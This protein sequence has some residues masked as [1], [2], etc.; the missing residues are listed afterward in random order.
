MNLS[1]GDIVTLDIGKVAHGG[2]FISRHNNQVV[3]VRH[4]ITGEIA[5]VKIT[6]INSKIAFGDA[7]EILKSS[8]YRVKPPC[9]YS[10]PGGCGG[11]DFQHISSMFQESLKKTIIEDQFKRITK[12]NVNV[13]I[14]S[15]K[16]FTG[17]HWRSRINLAISDNGKA[18]LYLYK[19]NDII[20]IDKCLI[21]VEEINKS[22]VFDKYWSDKKKLN[23]AV[24]SEKKLNIN[25][26]GNNI[27][28]SGELKEIVD[29]NVYI[30]SA[31][32]FWQSH[33]NAPHILI[34]QV[35]KYANIKI[36]DI[37]CDLYG[38]VGL[39][40]SPMQKLIGEKG[41]VHLIEKNFDCIK[42]ARKIFQN[43][44]NIIIH[45]GK[46]EQKLKKIKYADV[47]V[48]DPPRNGA[49]K[50]VI[51][52]IIK[53]KPRSIIYVSCDPASLARDTKIILEKNYILKDFIG[54]DL[55]PMTHHIECV[56]L[57]TKINL[58]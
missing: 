11:C 33:I 26:S 47:I 35:I 52:E 38:G 48:L 46:V 14:I 58:I 19:S 57:F 4:G 55:F 36:G 8:N 16:P 24:S 23:I 41:E 10:K 18:G 1:I 32:N 27:L 25:Q 56:A 22:S 17:L 21:A 5:K 51:S 39:F 9:K 34:N 42:D 44:K 7:I 37:I 40:S 6:S 20:E 28:G 13:K 53:K 30:V 43:K 45:H 29:D 2:H 50:Q 12:I 3:F 49:S 54:L 15:A 31:K